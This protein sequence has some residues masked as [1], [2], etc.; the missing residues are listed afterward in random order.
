MGKF[1]SFKTQKSHVFR[2]ENK[3]HPTAFILVSSTY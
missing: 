2:I 3:S 1:E